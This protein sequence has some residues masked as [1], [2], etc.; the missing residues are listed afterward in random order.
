M[1]EL[2]L[3]SLPWVPVAML[4]IVA[5]L[6]APTL[7]VRGR[8]GWIAVNAAAAALLL[9]DLIVFDHSGSTTLDV[10]TVFERGADGEVHVW[11]VDTVTGPLWW[12]HVAAAFYFGFAALILL[13]CLRREVRAPRPVLAAVFV[14]GYALAG[15]L[16]FEHFAAPVGLVWALGVTSVCLLT[17]PFFGY[18]CGRRG[19]G[20]GRF[21]LS[22]LLAN[23]IQR[24]LLV[25]ASLVATMGELGSHLDVH[26]VTDAA[27]P[28]FG[29]TEFE[30][31]LAAWSHLILLMHLGFVP[32]AMTL[33]GVVFG[34]L[35]WWVG[36][37]RPDAA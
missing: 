5:L 16:D 36:R 7:G 20:F 34:L 28:F 14:F 17:A 9:A 18:W 6:W 4:P 11:I 30:T 12:W 25:A 21:L 29:P 24:A 2:F 37:G 8:I 10:P 31:P 19:F 13:A 22:A 15:R 26:L 3:G 35:P 27:V 33:V 1:E 23:V 32:P